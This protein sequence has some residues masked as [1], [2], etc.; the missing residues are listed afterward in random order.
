MQIPYRFASSTETHL[1]ETTLTSTPQA[2]VD[3]KAIP[4]GALTHEF[5]ITHL[6]L[7]V[8]YTFF[9][10]SSTSP[11][12]AVPWVYK[13]K[14]GFL[15]LLE[16]QIQLSLDFTSSSSLS[17]LS[18]PFWKVSPILTSTRSIGFSAPQ[19]SST[20]KQ[21]HLWYC[22]QCCLPLPYP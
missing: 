13:N 19:P 5:F 21:S 18:Q 2:P 9:L 1:L 17:F 3:N 4:S 10:V 7:S 22:L 11:H 16:K 14:A 12:L 15:F 20:P 6:W 8:S